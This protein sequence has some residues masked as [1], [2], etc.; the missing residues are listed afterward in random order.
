MQADATRMPLRDKTVQL[1]CFSPPYWGLRKY[2]ILPLVWG[3][4]EGC[5]HKWGNLQPKHHPGQVAQTI[6]AKAG[7]AKGQDF[8]TGRFCRLCNAWR[9]D[10]GLE[11]TPELYLDHMML[12]MAEVWR[13]LR[14][15]GVCF[16]NVGD[17]YAANRGSGAKSVGKIQQGNIGSLLG[18][19]RVPPGIR[20]KSLCLIPQKFAIR[21]QE[22][23]WII[24][25]EII[26]AKPNPMPESVRDRP[27]RS[28]EQVWMMTKQGK[29]YWDQDAVR[30]VIT[31]YN[32]NQP[33]RGGKIKGTDGI[34]QP[35]WL[36]KLDRYRP[37]ET[38]NIRDVW[39]VATSPTPE[40]HF[41]TWPEKL[42]WRMIKAATKPGDIVLD[43]FCGTAK[44]V[45]EAE[46][47]NRI[48][49]GMDLS[50]EYLSEIALKRLAVPLQRELSAL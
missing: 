33:G 14:D 13:I 25:S 9:G 32:L 45:I 12:V 36:N 15:D 39:N 42:A 44:T 10:L 26:W 35:D 47:F 41:A 31:T 48:G 27:T 43:P 22:Q 11:P 21:C 38:R 40:A 24:R 6:G 49:I 5:Q 17:S 8:N 18:K 3:G 16:V 37:S 29:Y 1:V 4:N 20:E 7:P 23:G 2:S 30:E 46:R 34:S 28:H 19:L 50:W